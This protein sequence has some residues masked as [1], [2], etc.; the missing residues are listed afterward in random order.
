MKG[1]WKTASEAFLLI[2]NFYVIAENK[3]KYSSHSRSPLNI[4]SFWGVEDR[5]HIGSKIYISYTSWTNAFCPH[6]D[7]ETLS[8]GIGCPRRAL[9]VDWSGSDSSLVRPQWKPQM[10]CSTN[11]FIF[12]R[13]AQYQAV[14]CAAEM[15]AGK[16]LKAVWFFSLFLPLFAVLL[17]PSHHIW[18]LIAGPLLALNHQF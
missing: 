3:D 11:A 1:A 18:S 10:R 4:T 14:L 8:P 16:A 12:I 6:P 17:S 5:C 15:V 13:G 9:H 2:Y 7:T